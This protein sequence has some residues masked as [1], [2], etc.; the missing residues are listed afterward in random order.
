MDELDL[1]TELDLTGIV[2]LQPPR[3]TPLTLSV[4]DAARERSGGHMARMRAA[5]EKGRREY[6]SIRGPLGAVRVAVT[7]VPILQTIW[8]LWAAK[9]VRCEEET[10]VTAGE[11]VEETGL[12]LPSVRHVIQ[13]L[14]RNNAL[15]ATT[16]YVGFR[17]TR[18]HYSPTDAGVRV[19]SLI[20]LLPLGSQ[21][22]V[23]R[24]AGAWRARHA[25]EPSNLFQHAAF[26]RGGADAPVLDTEYA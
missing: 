17:G 7:H 26:L 24:T 10:G 1:E 23:G 6:I 5:A 3:R 20:S 25:T 4:E 9:R 8:R 13:S 2:D 14:L 21:V 11:I 16:R 19:L 18:A 22:Q 12:P 15:V